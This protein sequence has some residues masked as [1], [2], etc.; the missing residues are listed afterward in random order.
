MDATVRFKRNIKY[1]LDGNELELINSL[2]EAGLMN[3]YPMDKAK[4]ILLH[5]KYSLFYATKSKPATQKPKSI[6]S[7][8]RGLFDGKTINL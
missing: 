7:N 1:V 3:L 8:R 5:R 4:R 2:T 6:G